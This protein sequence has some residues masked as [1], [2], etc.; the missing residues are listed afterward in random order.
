MTTTFEV[1][2]TPADQTLD[3]MPLHSLWKR[4]EIKGQTYR[5][6]L[7]RSYSK[8][9]LVRQAREALNSLLSDFSQ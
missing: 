1:E 9:D 8:Q 2:V 7:F 3:G 5:T 6:L 4:D